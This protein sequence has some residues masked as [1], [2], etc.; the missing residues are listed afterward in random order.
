MSYPIAPAEFDD[1]YGRVPRLTVEVVV[2]TPDGLVLTRRSIEPCKGQWHLPGGTVLFAE[3]LPG[4][5][6]RVARNEL[7]VGV[8]VG[9]LLGYIEY[10]LML[11]GGYRG[12]PVGIAFETRI[13]D[14]EL[15]PAAQ[16]DEVG[17]FATLPPDMIA[18][19]SGFLR[20]LF[21]GSVVPPRGT[22]LI[23]G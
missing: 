10:P 5:V 20:S 18:E 17:V 11:R 21:G 16:S 9:R 23:P 12:W 13:V 14:G 22:L 4:A 6:R 1:I 7:G 19:Q 2:T 15:I 3:T 8:E